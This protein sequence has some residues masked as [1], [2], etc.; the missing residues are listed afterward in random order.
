[1]EAHVHLKIAFPGGIGIPHTHT[2]TPTKSSWSPGSFPETVQSH[3]SPCAFTGM[4]LQSHWA[5]CAFTGMHPHTKPQSRCP[6]QP[7]SPIPGSTF[8]YYISYKR[9]HGSACVL[10]VRGSIPGNFVALWPTFVCSLASSSSPVDRFNQLTLRFDG[11]RVVF[12]LPGSSCIWEAW[13][14]HSYCSTPRT[15]ECAAPR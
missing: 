14:S 12:S 10:V 5:P 4:H 15:L 1:M 11:A 6:A 2:H 13:K 9:Q 7:F 3:W 8:L